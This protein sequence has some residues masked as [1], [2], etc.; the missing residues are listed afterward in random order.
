MWM[1]VGSDGC[2]RVC[3]HGEEQK[4]DKK[5]KKQ[6]SRTC[7]PMS[8]HRKKMQEVGRDCYGGLEGTMWRNR[9]EGRGARCDMD[10]NTQG[11]QK[12]TNNGAKKN[13]N[14]QAQIWLT[15]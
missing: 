6:A 1:H 2:N 4:Q 13:E 10:G 8:V 5:S 3:G 9:E 7:F 11:G 14:E 12:K 15:R